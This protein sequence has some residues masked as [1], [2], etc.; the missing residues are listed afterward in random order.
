MREMRKLKI[1]IEFSFMNL[2]FGD[3]FLKSKFAPWSFF[4][5]F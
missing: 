5:F 3:Q 4:K 2:F 1:K